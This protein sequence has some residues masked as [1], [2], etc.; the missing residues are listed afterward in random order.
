MVPGGIGATEAAIVLL[1]MAQGVLLAPAALAAIAIRLS[2]LWFSIACG[3]VAAT[4]L[5]RR[6]ASAPADPA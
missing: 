1:L 2:G 4:I 5:E 6:A 3:L